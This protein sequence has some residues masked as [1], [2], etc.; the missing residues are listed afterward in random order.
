M[1]EINSPWNCDDD[2]SQI[3]CQH[4]AEQ[5]VGII[6]RVLKY[7]VWDLHYLSTCLPVQT[8][9]GVIIIP[10]LRNTGLRLKQ[11]WTIHYL[12][13]NMALSQSQA[14]IFHHFPYWQSCVVTVGHTCLNHFF[15]IIIIIVGISN[16]FNLLTYNFF[17]NR[18]TYFDSFTFLYYI[19]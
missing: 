8:D 17:L 16:W 2:P 7:E 1:K 10:W 12:F 6:W 13:A 5:D 4:G 11:S 9:P 14:F 15:F 19:L 18:H 3:S